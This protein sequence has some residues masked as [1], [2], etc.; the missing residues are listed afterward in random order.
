VP[1][2]SVRAKNAAAAA[3]RQAS[4]SRPGSNTSSPEERATAKE[5]EASL[6]AL[7][8]KQA[9]VSA[10]PT[11]PGAAAELRIRGVPMSELDRLCRAICPG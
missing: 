1:T 9:K 2:A 11:R 10:H 6:R 4:G 8:V 7:G 5:I 3:L